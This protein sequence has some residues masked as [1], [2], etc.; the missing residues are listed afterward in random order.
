MM[1]TDAQ[2]EQA[3]C[4]MEAMLRHHESRAVEDANRIKRDR[5]LIALEDARWRRQRALE[6]RVLRRSR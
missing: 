1:T 4:D 3:R 6:I 5:A 2:A